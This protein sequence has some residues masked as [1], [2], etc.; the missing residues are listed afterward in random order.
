MIIPQNELLQMIYDEQ[1]KQTEI[2][3]DIRRLLKPP[4]VLTAGTPEAN[5]EKL[6][7]ALEGLEELEPK[8]VIKPE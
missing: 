8:P 1:R 6:M 3:G 4:I 2:L 5:K 7:K